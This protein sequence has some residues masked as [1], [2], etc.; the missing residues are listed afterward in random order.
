MS[1]SDLLVITSD[2]AGSDDT[3]LRRSCERVG[4]ELHGYG[5]GHPWPG[6]MQRLK[7]AADYL[8]DRREQYVLFTDT[9]DT[10]ILDP[11][12]TIIAKFESLWCESLW[13][14]FL[15]AAEKNCYPDVGLA[16]LFD[17]IPSPYRY[18]NGGGWM[19]ERKVAVAYLDLVHA[20]YCGEPQ[21]CDQLAWTKAVLSGKLG[22]WLLDSGCKIFQT[23]SCYADEID[24]TMGNRVTD[25]YPSVFHFNGRAPGRE[26]MYERGVK[27]REYVQPYVR[28]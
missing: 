11:A 16:P 3:L 8:R 23:F 14:F 6:F 19:G 1:S 26:E 15:L 7:D 17:T 18:V 2:Y 4:I 24:E 28:P 10:F 12:K 5:A 20:M 22:F 27:A 25:S 13:C 9:S 21:D